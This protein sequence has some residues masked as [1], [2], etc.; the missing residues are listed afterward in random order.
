LRKFRYLIRPTCN[1]NIIHTIGPL[2]C[3]IPWLG[4][5]FS[6]RAAQPVQLLTQ[7]IQVSSFHEVLPKDPCSVSK[8][9]GQILNIVNLHCGKIGKQRGLR[10]TFSL[11]SEGL[12]RYCSGFQ[13]ALFYHVLK[14][15]QSPDR[16]Q[17]TF[18]M[19]RLLQYLR[20]VDLYSSR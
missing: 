12:L 14:I 10:Q 7:C 9:N 1:R 16:C 3:Q 15:L 17:K 13:K 19:I 8:K 18:S 11:Y 20:D 2:A 4:L 6:S 5:V